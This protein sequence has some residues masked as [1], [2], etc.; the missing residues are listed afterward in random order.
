MVGGGQ[1]WVHRVQDVSDPLRDARAEVI[2]HFA[3]HPFD[4]SMEADS[5]VAKNRFDDCAEDSKEEEDLDGEGEDEDEDV[6][7]R[8]SLYERFF[9]SSDALSP[10]TRRRKS[11]RQKL[12]RVLAWSHRPQILYVSIVLTLTLSV[13]L[14]WKLHKDGLIPNWIYDE[15]DERA[16]GVASFGR[17]LFRSRERV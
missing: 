4:S 12:G 13:V 10:T 1:V 7:P 11:K 3:R 9:G 2:F 17:E 5:F 6:V 8:R 14:T 15:V 16:C